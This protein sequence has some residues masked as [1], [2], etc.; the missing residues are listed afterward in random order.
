MGEIFLIFLA[1]E[2]IYRKFAP[3]SDESRHDHR[4]KVIFSNILLPAGQSAPEDRTMALDAIFAH[5]NFHC[6]IVAWTKKLVPGSL[7]QSAFHNVKRN[8]MFH[9]HA[10]TG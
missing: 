6:W 10:D 1:D 2:S 8:P 9:L 3:L 4:P 5:P 7:R